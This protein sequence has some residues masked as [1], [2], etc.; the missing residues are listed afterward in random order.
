MLVSQVLKIALARQSL[1]LRGWWFTESVH[2]ETGET[3]V[4]VGYFGEFYPQ[5]HF[6]RKDYIDCWA[7]AIQYAEN[8][9]AAAALE[10]RREQEAANALR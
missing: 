2:S 3:L 10:R 8:T 1:V 7:Q 5:R 4:S 6:Q 9:E